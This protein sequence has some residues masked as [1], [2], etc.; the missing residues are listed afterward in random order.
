MVVVWALQNWGKCCGKDRFSW[1]N[2][3]FSRWQK[4]DQMLINMVLICETR[5]IGRAVDRKTEEHVVRTCD[6][7]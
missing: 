5:P 2:C 7:K 1:Q 4:E 3:V 6:S